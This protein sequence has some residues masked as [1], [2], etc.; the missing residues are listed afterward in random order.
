MANWED[1]MSNWL[2]MSRS[3]WLCYSANAERRRRESEEVERRPGTRPL[4]GRG[5]GPKPPRFL[6]QERLWEENF[7]ITLARGR[8]RPTYTPRPFLQIHHR[9]VPHH[10]PCCTA[11]GFGY[12]DP[13]ILCPTRVN[14]PLPCL[15]CPQPYVLPFP[16]PQDQ[17]TSAES[18]PSESSDAEEGDSLTANQGS[19]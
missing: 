2:T 1:I 13:N 9:Y 3:R 17:E 10:L 16:P 5:V 8:S 19:P 7:H 14:N 18:S 6:N 4:V 15:H 11:A 12:V